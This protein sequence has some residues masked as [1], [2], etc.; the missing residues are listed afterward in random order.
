MRRALLDLKLL[1]KIGNKLGKKRKNISVMVSK[2]GAKL[3]ISSEAALVILAKEQG[4]G[5]AVYQRRL[6]PSKQAE[7]RESL[8]SIF[9]SRRKNQKTPR[10]TDALSGRSQS[11]RA[12][13]RAA[14]EYLLQDKKLTERCADIL[15]AR[16]NFDRP[17]NQATLV[18]EDRIRNKSQPPNKLVGEKL[19]DYAF[20]TDLSKTVLRI[21]S[22]AEEQRG[23]TLILKGVVPALRNITHHHLKTT[24]TREE[25]LRVCGFVD[26]LLRVV[27]N[28]TKVN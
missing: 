12:G 17:I 26:V 6:D 13:I 5:T 9:P 28:S 21:S 22:N 1:D 14:I 20:N 27:D 19:V 7:V 10:H 16:S 23:F 3:G 8:P 4:I 24:F 15:L 18:L 25:A 11:K 2:R